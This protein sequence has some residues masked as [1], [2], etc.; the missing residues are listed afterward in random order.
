MIEI[1]VGAAG[2][3]VTPGSPVI[4]PPEYEGPYSV[5][6]TEESQTLAT[7][8]KELTNDLTVEAIPADYVGSA[9]PRKG[10]ANMTA[11]GRTVTA[12]AG[13]YEEAASKS[14]AQGSVSISNPTFSTTYANASINDSTG[15]IMVST[16]AEGTVSPSVTAGYV[17]SVSSK[18][19]IA[20]ASGSGAV[21]SRA[22]AATITPSESQQT[23]VAKHKWTTGDIV[24]AAIPSDYVG[25]AIP[26]KAAADVSV[27][28]STVTIPA[29]YYSEPATV[30]V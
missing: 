12:P 1:Q 28:G 2:V 20:N 10:S 11:S 4:R 17:S 5:S 16:R 25:S 18:K 29:G 3:N 7:A 23:A 30:Q 24:V 15:A 9:V 21:V 8:K 14:V 6:P 19:I 27:S 26:R 13:Y 22:P